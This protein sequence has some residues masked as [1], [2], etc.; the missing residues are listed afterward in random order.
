MHL[1][2]RSHVRRLWFSPL[3]LAISSDSSKSCA[4][5]STSRGGNANEDPKLAL[6]SNNL[7]RR[8]RTRA[9]PRSRMMPSYGVPPLLAERPTTV[10]YTSDFLGSDFSSPS[11]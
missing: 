11:A 10:N 3:K 2:S 4:S 8:R 9:V 7:S 6:S 5:S 1:A